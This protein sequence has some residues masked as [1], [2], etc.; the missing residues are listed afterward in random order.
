MS[1]G[2]NSYKKFLEAILGSRPI[3]AKY[4]IKFPGVFIL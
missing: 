4:S 1:E 3:M 2:D